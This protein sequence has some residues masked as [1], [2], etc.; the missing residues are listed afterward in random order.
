M[1]KTNIS[2]TSILAM[3]ATALGVGMAAC[4]GGSPKPAAP[5]GSLAAAMAIPC[6][7]SA[8]TAA[9]WLEPSHTNNPS[10]PFSRR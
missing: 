9:A 6:P 5:V 4:G 3:A 7:T 1:K 2:R 8:A 10:R